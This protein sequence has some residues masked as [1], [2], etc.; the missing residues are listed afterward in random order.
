MLDEEVTGGFSRGGL[1]RDER[2]ALDG[3]RYPDGA[4]MMRGDAV[5]VD[6]GG[7]GPAYRIAG[8]DLHRRLVIVRADGGAGRAREIEPAR[9]ER[10]PG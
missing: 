3:F 4:Q 6:G 7:S 1:T 5:L 2:E 8:W 9:L 10:L